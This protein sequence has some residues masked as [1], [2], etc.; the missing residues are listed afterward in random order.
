MLFLYYHLTPHIYQRVSS[1]HFCGPYP[2]ECD[3][4]ISNRSI[5][6]RQSPPPALSQSVS[7]GLE[8]G[9]IREINEVLCVAQEAVSQVMAKKHGEVHPT[10]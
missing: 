4:R 1:V 7:R 8:A 3:K 10:G 2:Y 9:N 6:W 5:A